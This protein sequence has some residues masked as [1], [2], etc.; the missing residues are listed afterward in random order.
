[1]SHL[2]TSHNNFSDVK[3]NLFQHYLWNVKSSD[4]NPLQTTTKKH[5]S[6][7]YQT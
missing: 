1:V 2:V 5:Y 4:I 6:L 3:W 7:V